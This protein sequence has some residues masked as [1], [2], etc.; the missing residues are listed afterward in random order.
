[1]R[2]SPPFFRPGSPLQESRAALISRFAACNAGKARAVWRGTNLTG[3][4]GW[5]GWS[6]WRPTFSATIKLPLTGLRSRITHWGGW[7]RLRS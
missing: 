3:F 4:I 7:P 1:M 6:R 5:R 2:R